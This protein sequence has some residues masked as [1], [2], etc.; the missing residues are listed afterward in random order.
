MPTPTR[1]YLPKELAILVPTK[2]RPELV[3]RF[4]DT[5]AAQNI[6]PGQVIIVDSGTPVEDVVLSFSDR[7]RIEYHRTAR[8]GQI[9]QR[10]HGIKQIAAPIRL[11]SLFD[12]DVTL[13]S[14]ALEQMLLKWNTVADETAGIG[15]NITNMPRNEYR[16]HYAF[17]NMS[18]PE[19]GRILRSGFATSL[20]NISEDTQTQWLGGGY[21][22]WRRDI[23]ENHPQDT[24]RTRWAVGEDVRFSYPIGKK[25]PLHVCAAARIKAETVLDHAVPDEIERYRGEK[26]AL[27]QL[28][29]TS[30]DET[31]S[32]PHC[33][34]ML[35]GST[36]LKLGYGLL[37]QTRPQTQSALGQ[38]CA[39]GIYFRSLIFRHDLKIALEDVIS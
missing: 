24:L 19:P 33:V 6:S 9:H 20:C 2:D 7:L 1:P 21:T 14:G 15:Y 37:H 39:L 18:A 23:L 35:L 30:R 28:Y 11:V 5:L 13:E 8:P 32:A 26:W 34:W 22:V 12:D 4:L 17:F 31:L 29:L 38:L 10:N 16:T 3:K 27:A 25:H 36:A